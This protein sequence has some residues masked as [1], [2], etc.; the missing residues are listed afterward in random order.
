[1]TKSAQAFSDKKNG[2]IGIL[3]KFIDFIFINF[4]PSIPLSL[5]TQVINFIITKFRIF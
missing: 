1:M 3:L 4:S 5:N 2:L